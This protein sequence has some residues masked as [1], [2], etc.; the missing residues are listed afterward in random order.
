MRQGLVKGP[1]IIFSPNLQKL[2]EGFILFTQVI[3]SVEFLASM[4]IRNLKIL[5]NL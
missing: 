2:Q 3:F 5:H 1:L 4:D